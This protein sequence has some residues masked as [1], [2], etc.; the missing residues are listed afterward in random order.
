MKNKK[1]YPIALY[2]GRGKQPFY[3]VKTMVK[4]GRQISKSS[5][6][7]LTKQKALQGL[8]A[9]VKITF[10]AM[11]LAPN[12]SL[13]YQDCTNKISTAEVLFIKVAG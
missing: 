8:A 1:H 11:S 3:W 2:K 4:N 6:N 5:E 10:A 13:V 12:V 9:D 7:Y